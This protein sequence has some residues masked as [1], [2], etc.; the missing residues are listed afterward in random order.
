MEM[1]WTN[2]DATALRASVMCSTASSG[3]A[4]LSRRTQSPPQPSMLH[5]KLA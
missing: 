5:E 3:L 1:E 4:M 2:V